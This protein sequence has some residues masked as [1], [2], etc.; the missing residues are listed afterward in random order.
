MKL[1]FMT[2]CF[3]GIFALAA[4]GYS[5]PERIKPNVIVIITDDQGYADVGFNGCT[6]IPTPNIDR[7]AH[8][9]VKFTDGYVSYPVCGPS[10]AGLLTGRY[11]GRVGFTTNPKISPDHPET[12]IYIRIKNI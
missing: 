1:F 2:L 3:I 7:V 5:K 9:G 6:D 4:V 12:G 10:R 8:E 11:Q